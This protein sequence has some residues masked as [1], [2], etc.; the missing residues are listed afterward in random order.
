MTKLIPIDGMDNGSLDRLVITKDRQQPL[1]FKYRLL[2]DLPA[3]APAK[4]WLIKNIIAAGET[5]AWIG[6]P[7]SLKSAL[8]AELAF[9]IATKQDFHG[10][11]A[12][13]TGLVLYFA[14][15]R[16]DLVK[17]RL[18]ACRA[19]FDGEATSVGPIAIIPGLPNLMNPETVKDVIGTIRAA[20]DE[21]ENRPSSRSGTHSPSLLPLG[22]VMKT[23]PRT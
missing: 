18:L 3:D 22:V 15:E 12:K 10:Y 7:R 8:M 13:R 9:A 19:R 11:K 2:Q 4:D 21:L 14:L 23:R 17:R 16:V 5:S 20:E 6:P 1:K